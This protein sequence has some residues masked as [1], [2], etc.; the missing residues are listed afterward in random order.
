[1]KKQYKVFIFEDYKFNKGSKEL[2]LTYSF[3]SEVFF[4]EKITFDFEF[5]ENFDKKVL[6]KAFFSLWVMAGISYFKASLP[7]KISFKK[8]EL[9]KSQARF[10]NKIHTHGLGEFFYVNGIDPDGKINFNSTNNKTKNTNIESVIQDFK[11]GISLIPLG[12]GK[13]SLTTIEILKL[14]NI[15]FETITV[16]SDSRFEAVSKIIGKSHLNISR[17]ISP[18]LIKLN[19]EGALNGHVPI[20]AIWAFIFVCTAVL[21]GNKNIILSN[22]HSANEATTKYK[23]IL[24]N[25]QYSKSLEF[26]KDL[27]SYIAEN[28]TSEIY[29]F[30]FLRPLTELHIAQIFCSGII[31][32]YK[33]NFSSCNKNFTISKNDKTKFSWCCN[34]PKCAFVFVIFSAFLD[35]DKLID[36]F[37]ENLYKKESLNNIFIQLL[38][39][40]DSKPFECVGEIIEVRKAMIMAKDKFPEVEQ[41]LDKLSDKQLEEAGNFDYERLY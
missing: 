13:D 23:G 10:F 25:H 37:A 40:T 24:I 34:C 19:K 22:E 28:I 4:E 14:K 17:K 36:I 38:G 20:S 35:K 12:G 15:D 9:S 29:Y 1:M 11:S 16:D 30:S 5:V 32:K 26:E 8:G 31:D 6:D 41:F 39:L 27:Q 7:P 18:E 21:R 3:D 33:E 2:F